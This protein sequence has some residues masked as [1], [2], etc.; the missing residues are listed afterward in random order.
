MFAHMPQLDTV[1]IYPPERYSYGSF[2]D[3]A[4]RET[5]EAIQAFSVTEKDRANAH[6]DVIFEESR[7][8]LRRD[9]VADAID[10][11]G[12]EAEETSTGSQWRFV[13]INAEWEEE[14]WEDKRNAQG[15]TEGVLKDREE[16]EIGGFV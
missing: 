1:T 16:G 9:V 14:V 2:S 15:E 3:E 8:E 12:G 5:R 7:Y 11:V 6:F 13:D 10:C 4:R